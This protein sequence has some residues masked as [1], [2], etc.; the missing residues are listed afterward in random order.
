MTR[1]DDSRTPVRTHAQQRI[2]VLHLYDDY[3]NIY[4]D[5]GN[6][7]VLKQRCAWRGI[8]CEV[9]G[10]APGEQFD[11]ATYDLI[12][13]GGGQD[14]DQRMIATRMAEDCTDA[15]HTAVDQGVALLAVCGGYQLLGAHYL[16]TSGTSQPGVGVFDLTTEAGSSRLIGNVLIRADL[17]AVGSF[18]PGSVR[19]AGFENHAGRTILGTSA[20][21]LGR[22]ERGHGNDGQSG[23]EGCI[24]N[25]AVGT[26][27][28]GPLLPRNSELADWL[29][30]A[31]LRHAGGDAAVEALHQPIPEGVDVFASHARDVLASR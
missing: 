31:A 24:R 6:I 17:P 25:A 28:H 8:T 5:R 23:W 26:Y 22:V 15:L 3:L 19:I 14:R 21:P 30:A 27:L 12:Y 11:P 2:R 4:A 1:M 16:D 10:L 9:H 29:I 13:V 18:V 7:M 20:V